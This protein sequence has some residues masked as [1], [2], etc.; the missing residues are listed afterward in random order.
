M[1]TRSERPRP[2]AVADTSN[3]P[4]VAVDSFEKVDARRT[5][6][7]T[8]ISW[9]GWVV[10][11]VDDIAVQ[12]PSQLTEGKST[13]DLAACLRAAYTR[14]P[15]CERDSGPS[16][17]SRRVRQSGPM[18][19][20]VAAVITAAVAATQVAGRR[21]HERPCD[22]YTCLRQAWVDLDRQAPFCAVLATVR[23]AL[24]QSTLA[25]FSVSA[26]PEQARQLLHRALLSVPGRRFGPSSSKSA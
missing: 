16:T 23:D 11:I 24:P 5:Y 15:G 1:M 18:A 7:I 22:V 9:R 12:V 8:R 13:S 10:H 19:D 21:R 14:V 4:V 6:Q 17:G 2:G 25:D 3:I 20:A 26:S